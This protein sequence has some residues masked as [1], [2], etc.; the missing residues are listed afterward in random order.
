MM[1]TKI[2]ENSEKMSPE[3]R[4]TLRLYGDIIHLPPHRSKVHPP[5]SAESRAAQFAPFAALT[6]LDD[7]I[8]ET[9]RYTEE[10]AALDENRQ[11]EL[12]F[13][14]QRLEHRQNPAAEITWFVPDE[15]KEGGSYQTVSG[16]I[17]RI[18]GFRRVIVMEDGTEIP[19]GDIVSLEP[20]DDGEEEDIP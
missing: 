8:D 9:A 11:E 13:A 1:E 20:S 4:E 3:E 7:E 10:Q 17:R 19:A 2:R 15:R 12:N 5:L 14:L 18:D 16:R 6:G